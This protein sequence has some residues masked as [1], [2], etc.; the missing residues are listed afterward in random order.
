MEISKLE[1]LGRN[2]S[3]SY[4]NNKMLN[5]VKCQFE[6]KPITSI[7]KVKRKSDQSLKRTKPSNSNRKIVFKEPAEES[8]KIQINQSKKSSE[9]SVPQ[10][11]NNETFEHVDVTSKCISA[12]GYYLYNSKSIKILNIEQQKLG[13]KERTYCAVMTET[14]GRSK[15]NENMNSTSHSSTK[16]VIDIFEACSNPK[17]EVIHKLLLSTSMSAHVNNFSMMMRRMQTDE[18]SKIITKQD[19]VLSLLVME[20]FIHVCS[21]YALLAVFSFNYGKDY[22][23]SSQRGMEPIMINN[24]YVSIHKNLDQSNDVL[25]SPEDFDCFYL[26]TKKTLDFVIL[27]NSHASN[28]TNMQAVVSTVYS[29]LANKSINETW[30]ETNSAILQLIKNLIGPENNKIVILISN[31]MRQMDNCT[32]DKVLK[33]LISK[34]KDNHPLTDLNFDHSLMNCSQNQLSYDIRQRTGHTFK[35]SISK[36]FCCFYKKPTKTQR[37]IGSS[38]L[39]LY[40]CK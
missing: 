39:N 10:I 23:C 1:A 18:T 12:A 33:Q 38:R 8:E 37:K 32:K 31:S 7:L 16:T 19:E 40:S 5:I 17:N 11:V 29:K 14:C 22:Y 28:K 3:N 13:S 34:K 26:K 24:N 25:G 6:S 35:E 20:D 15:C 4:D 9:L 30:N 2:R 36:M 21:N 27:L